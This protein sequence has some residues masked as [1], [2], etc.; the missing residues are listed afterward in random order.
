M[1]TSNQMDERC[2]E[3]NY[4]HRLGYKPRSNAKVY[5]YRYGE[6]LVSYSTRMAYKILGVYFFHEE[7]KQWYTHTTLRH[8]REWCGMSLPQIREYMK[9]HPDRVFCD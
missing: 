2:G 5:L 4:M 9:Q 6:K 7:G 1:T 8:L 3:Y